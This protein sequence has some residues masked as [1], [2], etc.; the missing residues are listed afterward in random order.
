MTTSNGRSTE[1]R[2]TGRSPGQW[3]LGLLIILALA[4]SILMVFTDQLSI[5][6]SLA[7]IAALWLPPSG[8]FFRPVL[9]AG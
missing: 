2:R 9:R 8:R 6:G 5:A 3:L 1:S 4:A 7:V